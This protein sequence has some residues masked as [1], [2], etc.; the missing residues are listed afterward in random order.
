VKFGP[1]F[2][3]AMSALH[4]A[5]RPIRVTFDTNTL[6]KAARPDRHPKDLRRTHYERVHAALLAGTL[7]GY[8]SETLVTLEGIENKDRVNV[9]G[10]TRLQ[11]HARETGKN[12]VTITLS[13]MQDRNPLP[14]EFLKRIEA[15][16]KL[17]MRALR[18]PA[19]VGW[20]C[21]EDKDG[22]FFEPDDSVF[23]LSQRLDKVNEV[24]TAINGRGVGHAA[25]VALGL[26]FSARDS[27][28]GELWFLGL[29]RVRNDEE[30]RSV[31]K[32]VAEWADADSIA[33]HVGYGIDFLCSEDLGRSTG[34]VRSV[35]DPVNRTWLTSTYGVRF[36]TLTEL[37]AMV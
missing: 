28:S 6:D 3:T 35:F 8:F 23:H 27:A 19:R 32:A 33:S 22:K 36:V 37:A 5:E 15:A 10:S 11:S 24:A 31:Q 4:N 9:L 1:L 20:I 25:A 7:K 30:R 34:G 2:D 26:K 14:L 29:R 18:G 16:Q 13:V 12:Q 17:G 21:V